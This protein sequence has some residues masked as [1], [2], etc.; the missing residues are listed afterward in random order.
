[1][2]KKA[3]AKV[4]D[5]WQYTAVYDSTQHRGIIHKEI[6]QRYSIVYHIHWLTEIDNETMFTAVYDDDL[7]N[8][9]YWSKL[10]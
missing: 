10:S 4:G 1:M 6:K 2:R 3:V 7:R 9:K 8:K 5:L